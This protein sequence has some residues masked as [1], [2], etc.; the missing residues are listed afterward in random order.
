MEAIPTEP[1]ELGRMKAVLSRFG[2]AVSS[3]PKAA[4]VRLSGG[5]AQLA[6]HLVFGCG[7]GLRVSAMTSG[8]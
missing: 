4:A 7:I 5:D 6:A 3:S 2:E 8:C 1:D